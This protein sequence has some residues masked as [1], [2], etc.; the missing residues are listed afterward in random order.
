MESEIRATASHAQY[1]HLAPT[2]VDIQPTITPDEGAMCRGTISTSM[3]SIRRQ[4]LNGLDG[5]REMVNINR[6]IRSANAA[7]TERTRHSLHG[8]DS[9]GRRL[10]QRRGRRF[11]H[12]QRNI[13]RKGD[14]IARA[15]EA[16]SDS[17]FKRREVILR[18]F[19]SF[20]HN[21]IP[22]Q[23]ECASDAI[24]GTRSMIRPN[25]IYRRARR[26]R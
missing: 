4:S 5:I 12:R 17:L 26:V 22:D 10:F 7:R 18:L 13:E 11:L 20:R 14:G 15:R 1:G 24:G 21:N 6:D 3:P 8:G 9:R 19:P 16:S 2:S 25:T 23:F